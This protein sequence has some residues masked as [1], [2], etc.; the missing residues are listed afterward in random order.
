MLNI[1]EIVNNKINSML[2][3]N[4]IKEKIEKTVEKMR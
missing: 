4:E 1:T 2:E 3:S